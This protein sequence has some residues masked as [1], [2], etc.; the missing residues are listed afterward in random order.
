M[1]TAEEELLDLL[2]ALIY[3]DIFD[4]AVTLDELCQYSRTP[5]DNAQLNRRLR[6]DAV[7]GD[8]VAERDGLY[9]LRHRTALI[10]QRPG[11]IARA[12]RLQRRALSVARVLRHFP[13]VRGL[14]LTGSVSADDATET[15]DIDLLVIVAAGRIGTVFL[16]LGSLSRLVGGSVFCP[17]WYMSEDRL[18]MAPQSLYITREFAQARS[19]VG[20]A[21]ALR[22]SNGWINTA[23]PNWFVS[24][25][26]DPSLRARTRFQRFLEAPLLGMAGRYVEKRARD[27]AAA[28]LR[29]HYARFG[30]DVP[31]DVAARFEAGTSLGFHGYRYEAAT[32]KAH[33][34]R[35]AKLLER[36]RQL[37]RDFRAARAQYQSA[38][39]TRD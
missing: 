36:I 23:F 18:N 6:D 24:A 32:M 15:A 19:L 37:T 8:I 1:P 22:A 16:L 26:V 11:R 25:E 34:A 28:R 3:G 10:D 31:A 29:A 14:V 2:D 38:A 12:R 30:L 5:I 27:I 33:A 39:I 20:C 7:I 17:N 4:C 21:D 9:C 13:F 35:R